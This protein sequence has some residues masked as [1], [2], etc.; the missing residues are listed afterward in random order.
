MDL[1]YNGPNAHG[2][3]HHYANV[4]NDDIYINNLMTH[5]S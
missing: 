3:L 2:D 4:T 1:A 5:M